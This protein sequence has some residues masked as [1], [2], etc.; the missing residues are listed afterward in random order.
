MTGKFWG[1]WGLCRPA[2]RQRRCWENA[3][4][5]LSGILLNMGRHT[6]SRS[7]SSAGAAG[8]DWS[9]AYRLF[10][11]G[12]VDTGE[13][14]RIVREEA[15]RAL[16]ANAPAVAFIDDTLFKKSGPRVFG[17]G[18]KRDPLGPKFSTNL[19]W[20]QR[21]MQISLAYP[22]AEGRCRGI[23]VSLTHCP[24]P[25][26]PGRKATEEDLARYLALRKENRLP[27]RA[28]ETLA[29]FQSET[30]GRKLV[31]AGDG[32]YTNS[33]V[34]RAIMPGNAFVGRVRKDARIFSQPADGQTG[35]GRKKYYGDALPTPQEIQSD[36]S[37]WT[38]AAASTGNGRHVFGLKSVT[39]VRSKLTGDKDVKVVIVRPLRYRLSKGKRLL[40][41]DAAYL[42]CTDPDM[43]DAEILQTYLKR[44]EIEINF[45]DEKSTFGI[46]QSQTRAE[47]AVKTYPAFVAAVYGLFMLA[48]KSRYGDTNP[49]VY[50][51]WRRTKT[52][53]R[54][55]T[56]NFLSVFR[57]E[58]LIGVAQKNGFMPSMTDDTK[59]LLFRSGW[60]APIYAATN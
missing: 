40:Y 56:A 19:V 49:A 44:W 8:R 18:W 11:R 1:L 9:A 55:S 57:T 13:L 6:I 34:C 48:A 50:P 39:G 17:A 58:S 46:H 29:R 27:K 47:T 25:K 5:L 31:I 23:P 38:E 32:G 43:P 22:E 51:K 10:E 35:R 33:T 37:P 60:T 45:R 28:A 21:F 16:P 59:P 15:L 30:P 2:F 36:G 24:V 4:A 42:I 12:R 14:F 53:W 54:S 26:K 41:R 7:I 52:V 20:A 3:G